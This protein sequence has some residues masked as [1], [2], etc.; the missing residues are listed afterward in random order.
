MPWFK[1]FSVGIQDFLE[2]F[3]CERQQEQQR[4]VFDQLLRF[5]SLK[6]DVLQTS[7]YEEHDRYRNGFAAA[8]SADFSDMTWPTRMVQQRHAARKFNYTK[9]LTADLLLDMP[10]LSNHWS[11][12]HNAHFNYQ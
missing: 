2:P 10:N 8:D 5:M 3:E 1:V 7:A 6:S 12:L 11:E 4:R 9:T